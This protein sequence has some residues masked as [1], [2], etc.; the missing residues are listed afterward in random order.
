MNIYMQSIGSLQYPSI[1]TY[2]VSFVH[3]LPGANEIAY[4][5]HRVLSDE[6]CRGDVEVNTYQSEAEVP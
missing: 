6:R 5:T 4:S 3:N 2:T 1:H